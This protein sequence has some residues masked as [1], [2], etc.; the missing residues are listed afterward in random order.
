MKVSNAFSR[1]AVLAAAS[2]A[3]AGTAQAEQIVVSNYGVSANGM[4]F[5][6]AMEKGF[7]KE[8]GADVT[9]ILS[10][11]GGGTTLR[12]MLAGDAPYA[13]VNPNAII[14]AIQQGADIKII[15]DNVLTV[16]E[17]I[18]AVKPDSPIQSVK[19]LKGKKIAFTNPR[20]TSQGLAA[21]VLQ[22]GGLKT[23]DAELVKTGG[24]GEGV[25][26]LDTGLVD[27]A[28]IPEPLWSKF[29][30]KY[31][32]IAKAS[33]LLPPIANVL[34]AAAGSAAEKKGDFIKAVIRARR[35]AVEFMAQNPDEAGDIIAKVYNLEPEVAR[36]AVKNLVDSRTNGIEY[37]GTGQI[38][39]DGLE[40]SVE[41]QKMIGALSGD[42]DL[43]AIIDTQF[44]PDDIKE[45]K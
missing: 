7:F 9:G 2:L 10:S 30:D 14:A 12:N 45:L 18:W 8:E 22:A 19:D 43:K 20:S 5:A 37:W 17:F 31:R 40:K 39:L 16:A 41:V 33:D 27:V 21:L 13:E 24:F 34:G 42:V 36:S 1:L 38:H 28:P 6:V 15:S 23:E 11:A 32:P 35:R 26:A 29:K 3:L 25:A 44:L 4:P